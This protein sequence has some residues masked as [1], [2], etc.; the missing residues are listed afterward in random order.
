VFRSDGALLLTSGVH[1]GT[2]LAT[3]AGA[4]TTINTWF[5]FE[6]EVFISATAGY[7]NVRKNGNPVNDFTSATNLV[8]RGGT[9][10]SYANAIAIGL[11]ANAGHTADDLYWRSDASSVAWMGDIRCYTR[12]P[13]SDAAVQFSRTPLTMTQTNPSTTSVS[14]VN[15]TARF[16]SFTCT[17]D[18]TIN[19]AVFV[20]NAGVSGNMKCAIYSSVAGVPAAV[21][22]S[23]GPIAAVAAGNNT[24]TFT[25]GVAVT[26]GQV[27]WVG[28]MCDTGGGSWAMQGATTAGAT[29]PM[30]YATFPLPNPTATTGG[31][32]TAGSIT[33]NTANNYSSV[34][35]A[36]QDATTSYVY[37]SVVGH[38]DLYGIA[39]IASTPLTTF[40]V[41]T[42]AYAIKS[43]AGTRTMA[44][45]LKSGGS[46]V[47]SP[48]VVLTPSN[49]QW[50]W[51]HDTVDPN[52]SSA[53]TAVAVN[54]VTCGPVIIA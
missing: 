24:F 10:N 9:A 42:R 28:V 35:E 1:T 21:L 41:T 6:I 46:T 20:S 11:G 52:T 19:T 7:M 12:A 4:V 17:L 48:T 26:R 54:A 45:Q 2:V 14:I 40:A 43:D 29:A 22:G 31:Q 50:A 47:A 5:A 13:A 34:A 8:T 18:G 36:Q 39:A 15:T 53:W 33:Y 32:Q 23:S 30:T 49:W 44:V 3:Y 51:R 27:I 16:S 38:S 25:P 37:D